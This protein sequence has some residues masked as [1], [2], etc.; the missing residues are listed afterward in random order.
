[1]AATKMI[2]RINSNHSRVGRCEG[3]NAM[4]LSCW[5]VRRDDQ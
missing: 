1:M 2:A 3:V 5:G 4:K